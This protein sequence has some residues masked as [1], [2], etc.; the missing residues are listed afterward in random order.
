MQFAPTCLTGCE[1]SLAGTARGGIFLRSRGDASNGRTYVGV[2]GSGMLSHV[3]VQKVVLAALLKAPTLCDGPADAIDPS[4][5]LMRYFNSLCE[6]A[7]GATLV[8]GDV[9]EYLNAVW[10][11][12]GLTADAPRSRQAMTLRSMQCRAPWATRSRRPPPAPPRRQ[13]SVAQPH[14]RSA[15]RNRR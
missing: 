13:S 2:F 4:W 6:L 12:I 3:A 9:R 7:R 1:T 5:T 8:Q 14:R 10:H 11:R 15:R